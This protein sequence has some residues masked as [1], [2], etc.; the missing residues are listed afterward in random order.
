MSLDASGTY[1]GALT[2]AKWKGRQYVRNRVDPANPQSANQVITRNAV[3]VLAAGVSF[4]NSTAEKRA[5]ETDIDKVELISLAPSGQA[6]NGFLTKSG[7]GTAMIQYDAATAAYGALSAPQK[8]AW[9]TAAQG[10]TP[11]IPDV[12]QQVAGGGAGTPMDD[13][14]VFF[15]F[16]YGLYIAGA[17]DT[18]PGAVPPVYA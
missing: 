4:A 15:H 13:G 17:M 1:A 10:L 3:R 9:A 11:P 8:A 6:W 14:E 2:F 12:A 5:G 16:C 18:E 7:I